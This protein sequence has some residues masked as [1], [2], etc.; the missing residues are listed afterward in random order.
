MGSGVGDGVG[1]GVAS[2]VHATA[3]GIV[4]SLVAAEKIIHGS[5]LVPVEGSKTNKLESTDPHVRGV[6]VAVDPGR[7]TRLSH[8]R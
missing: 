6:E 7:R 2:V 1:S 3:N 4:R 5:A 8:A